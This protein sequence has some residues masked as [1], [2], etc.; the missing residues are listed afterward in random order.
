MLR[1]IISRFL[2]CLFFSTA[3]IW[4]AQPME[5]LTN[6]NVIMVHG[7]ATSNNGMDK[8]EVKDSIC[9]TSAYDRYG[10]VFGAADMMGKNGYK[11]IDKDDEYNLTYWLDSVVFENVAIED[12]GKRRYLSV[13]NKRIDSAGIEPHF[14][15]IYLQRP[16]MNPA[17]APSH[18]AHEIGDRTWDGHEKCGGRRSLIEEAQEVRA[19]GRKNLD[20]LRND[21]LYDSL[22][23]SRNILIAHSMGGVASREYVQGIFYNNDVDKLITL[24][25]P[26][27]G[28]Y[29]L[30]G[31]LDT[32]KYLDN[33]IT[34]TIMQDIDWL[35]L[36]WPMLI[37]TKVAPMPD[38]QSVLF[39]AELFASMNSTNAITNLVTDFVLNYEYNENDPLVNYIRP[40]SSD[41][42]KL[43]NGSYNT[44]LPMMRILNSVG[45]LT[46]GSNARYRLLESDSKSY[47][48]VPA[49]IPDAIYNPIQNLIAQISH[50]EVS[51]PSYYNNI[52]SST[53]LGLFGGMTITDHGSVLIPHWSGSAKDVAAL[54][55]ADVRRYTYMANEN[56]QSFSY[57]EHM[58]TTAI[59]VGA[60]LVALDLFGIFSGPTREV[61]RFGIAISTA[62]GL[63]I[64]MIPPTIAGVMDME[65]SHKAPT[66]SGFQSENKGTKNT[67]SKILIGQDIVE[68]YLMEEF[69]YEKPFVNL[70]V[71]STYDKDWV[72]QKQDALGLHTEEDFYDTTLVKDSNGKD[73]IAIT[74]VTKTVPIYVA[75]NISKSNSIDFKSSTDWEM[76]GAKKVRWETTAKDASGN[77]IPIR[78]VDRYPMPAVMVKNF[79]EKYEFEVDDLMPHRLRQIRMNFNFNE[80]LAWE[81]DINKKEDA[82]DACTVYKRTPASPDWQPLEKKEPHPVRKSGEFIF[83]PR[84]Y[85]DQLGII[86]KDNQNVVT[87]STVNK[88][89]LK[90]S[91]RF[92][93]MFKATA[94]L[95][96]PVW[97]VRNIKV[98]NLDGFRVYVSAL[99]YQDISVLGGEEY[100]Q[101][102]V[103]EDALATDTTHMF[104][105]DTMP[106]GYILKS[107]YSDYSKF[108]D[109]EGR[110]IWQLSIE[111]GDTS[112][113]TKSSVSAMTIPFVLDTTP[114]NTN[115]ALERNVINL[116]S[117][118][119][120][121]RFENNIT[122]NKIDES[123]RLVA[124]FLKNANGNTIGTAKYTEVL[125]QN[126]GI[127]LSDFKD[128]NNATMTALPDGKY[129]I[130]SYAFDGSTGSLEQ[131][132]MLN[133]V[134][135]GR[136]SLYDL[137]K[138]GLVK[139]G[140]IASRDTAIFT[141]D[142]QP[143]EF[144]FTL[145]EEILNQDNLLKIALD[146]SDV[147]GKDSAVARYIVS[148]ADT[149]KKDTLR[150]SDTLH[151]S[152]GIGSK[153]WNELESMAI[154]DG[155]YEVFI[156]VLDESG[157]R[158]RKKH[159]KILRID[160]TPPAIIAVWTA[161]L[162]YKDASSSYSATIEAHQPGRESH[163]R[164]M[165]CRYRVN[166]GEWQN[167]AEKL[168]AKSGKQILYFNISG[169]TVGSE[170]GKRRLEAGCADWAGN[171]ASKLELFYIGARYPSVSY[172]KDDII[173]DS[174]IAIRGSA[175]AQPSN[176]L[177]GS[178]QIEWRRQGD[179]AW[180]TKGVDVGAS[181]RL[182]ADS[183]WISRNT[184]SDEADL[185]FLYMAG[186]GKGDYEL[187]LSVRD[188]DD[189]QWRRDT[190][191]FK[192]LPGT[193]STKKAVKSRLLF[194]ASGENFVPDEG[195]LFLS[196]QMAGASSKDYRARIYAQDSEG[197]SL[198]MASADSLSA[199]P[200][201]GTP[202]SFDGD[203]VW[204]WSEGDVY[205]LRWEGLP[206]GE[207]I[208]IHYSEGKFDASI[209][210]N[211]CSFKDT[212][213]AS[214]KE[215]LSHMGD[216]ILSEIIVPQN[217]DKAM[218]FNGKSGS[219]SFKNDDVF[220]LRLKNSMDTTHKVYL[221][222]G[223]S[224][225]EYVI[226]Y[227]GTGIQINKNLYGLYYKWNGMSN[228][229]RYPQGTTVT[230]YAEAFENLIGG[231]AFRDSV[232]VMIL[233]PDLRIVLDTVPLDDYY[234][235]KNNTDSG[236][237][238]G[239]MT[240]SYGIAGRDAFVD[241]YVKKASDGSI[242][243]E[244]LKDSLHTTSRS[245]RA[246]SLSWSGDDQK[247]HLVLESGNYYFEII[248]REKGIS[249]NPQTDVKRLSFKISLAPGVNYV[250]DVP[251]EH[252]LSSLSLLRADSIS[253]AYWQ[254][255]PV[256]DYLVQANASGKWLPDSLRKVDVEWN[257]KGTQEIYGYPP[258]RFSLAVKRQREELPLVILYR[259]KAK[260]NTMGRTSTNCNW[261]GR[262]LIDTEYNNVVHNLFTSIFEG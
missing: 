192:Y 171:F 137:F 173:E 103:N 76:M 57:G 140:L 182:S 97:P 149:G 164:E 222:K 148:F 252:P 236:Y 16:F 114:P 170:D 142:M 83:N 112:D 248:A 159:D 51:N 2:V 197:N 99:D 130:V 204:F 33:F 118:V 201:A 152:N 193:D 25:S 27:K 22:P 167:I 177:P 230:F 235:I 202:D 1:S 23:P 101:Q 162:V 176:D 58:I 47:G 175:P 250:E 41:L 223:G 42:K 84:D 205:N 85:Y 70:R 198:F 46:V 87:I 15:P 28:T 161:A 108:Q 181:K 119:F 55:H 6:Y 9:N 50:T 88:I 194:A 243:K 128:L 13:S 116:N 133:N 208:A 30:D 135:G 14:S 200:Y 220:W 212:V 259:I 214:T 158:S 61:L 124:V 184:H 129:K 240:V 11:D 71:F 190:S 145:S 67:Y 185:G 56:T 254:Y 89:G 45:S 138:D 74:K 242:V 120:L 59:A 219:L 211:G 7:A 121:A 43:N 209:C 207:E 166:D 80:E 31:L 113:A 126:F 251:G 35:L 77:K 68:P 29:S 258:Q 36:V 245:Y 186:L 54:D 239:D 26:H 163:L 81:C 183:P 168:Q 233:K 253:P 12:N 174:L 10:R 155:D 143:P 146:V 144:S 169:N 109:I 4:A 226:K 100:L 156:D 125:A 91:Q 179:A 132:D 95:L 188:C 96:Q 189:C 106:S 255:A 122:N 63:S 34:E 32:K 199:S 232:S 44:N 157:N 79:I 66:T 247:G 105:S 115:L 244:L 123:L 90:N 261:R 210:G 94:D 73:S 195:F 237:V 40:G 92:Y 8:K 262:E 98:S 213:L 165:Q 147:N 196:L 221:G 206:E 151:L 65:P 75:D 229:G 117:E 160:R 38:W 82:E 224:N 249:E 39:L 228:T 102:D 191:V 154:P 72:D 141:I 3:C 78:H 216:N 20:S 153:E 218:A 104:V 18:N 178:Y 225:L 69:L 127:K 111:T 256:S 215:T 86:Q 134:V 64:H 107:D 187:L 19:E 37:A 52:L 60:T 203:G 48:G 217:F 241:A 180:Q 110:Y 49:I 172:P 62:I 93:Y 231:K 150:L 53:M 238:L 227:S 257:A 5:P 21:K 17:E 260:Q 24:D 234:V 131:Y 136:A 139:Q 246:S